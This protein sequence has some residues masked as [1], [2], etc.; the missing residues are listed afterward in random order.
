MLDNPVARLMLFPA[1]SDIAPVEPF[2]AVTPGKYCSKSSMTLAVIVTAIVSPT[3]IV[4]AVLPS[5]SRTM[6]N[7]SAVM[8]VTRTISGEPLSPVTVQ[9]NGTAGNNA[10]SDAVTT[11]LVPVVAGEGAV[12]TRE[13]TLFA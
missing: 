9:L 1:T 8:F 11:K 10:P 7:V 6:V 3:T 5:C 4:L 2:S 13:K 12:A